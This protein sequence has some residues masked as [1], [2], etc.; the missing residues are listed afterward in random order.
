[1]KALRVVLE[2]ITS[3]L[4]SGAD[5][6]RRDGRRAG[7]EGVRHPAEQ[8][9]VLDG[10]LPPVGIGGAAVVEQAG[11]RRLVLKGTPLAHPERTSLA[12]CRRV[13]RHTL[14]AVW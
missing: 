2:D 4:C 7:S 1:M 6:L 14:V 11:E 9:V 3:A 13:T 8:R 5:M 12:G 10:P